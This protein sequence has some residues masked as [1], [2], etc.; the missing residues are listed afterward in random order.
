MG[1][2]IPTYSLFGD[3]K[4]PRVHIRCRAISVAR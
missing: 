2:R 1:R 3:Q 4:E